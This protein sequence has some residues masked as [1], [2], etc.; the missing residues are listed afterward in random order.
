MGSVMD[1]LCKAKTELLLAYQRASLA[2][3]KAVSELS[4]SVG[5]IPE[6][7]FKY[8]RSA[9][10]QSRKLCDAAQERLRVHVAEHHC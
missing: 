1:E 8:L 5:V 7:E 6:I 3:S 2:Y 4:H 9:A 10:E